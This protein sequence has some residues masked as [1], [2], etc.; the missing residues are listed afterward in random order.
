PE[1]SVVWPFRLMTITRL[2]ACT[3]WPPSICACPARRASAKSMSARFRQQAD[4]SARSSD[5]K[6]KNGARRSGELD[7]QFPSPHGHRGGIARVDIE[8]CQGERSGEAHDLGRIAG[9]IDRERAR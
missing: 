6:L 9:K 8:R 5:R 7:A 1:I 2:F 3:I 4:Q